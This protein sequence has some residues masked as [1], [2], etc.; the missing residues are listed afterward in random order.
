MSALEVADIF[1]GH[2]ASWRKTHARHISL[3]QLKIMHARI[4]PPFCSTR[5]TLRAMSITAGVVGDL[6][7]TTIRTAQY[8]TTEFGTTAVLNSRHNLELIKTDVPG[9][10]FAPHGTMAAED[11][12]DL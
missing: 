1:R 4:E 11:I 7:L 9:V 10:C 12:R 8:V 2:G 5:L 6:Y 3:D